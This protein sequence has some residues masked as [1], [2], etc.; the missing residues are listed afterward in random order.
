MLCCII[1][2]K[3][4]IIQSFKMTHYSTIFWPHR[5]LGRFNFIQPKGRLCPLE[6]MNFW[7]SFKGGAKGSF[8]IQNLILR[9]LDL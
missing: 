6:I 1:G 7:K 2:V 5:D 4:E 3:A 8:P 9:N